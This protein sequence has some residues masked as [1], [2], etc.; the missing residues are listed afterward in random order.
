VT[1]SRERGSQ[2]IELALVL[3]P[4]CAIVFLI[5]DIAWAFYVKSTL[6]NAVREGVRYAVTSQTMTG[7]GQDASIKS[8]VQQNAMGL[9]SGTTNAALIT[10]QYYLPNTLAPVSGLNSNQGGNIV[11]VYVQSYSLPP[12]GPILRNPTPLSLG[13]QAY[14]RMEGSP[15]GVPPAR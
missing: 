2:T 10:I 5:L 11:E 4:L 13:A 8:V 9:L 12:L 3:L 6:Q 1:K 7:L 15:G 14:D